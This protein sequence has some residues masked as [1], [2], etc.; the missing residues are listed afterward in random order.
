MS[1]SLFV[2]CSSALVHFS[3]F[4]GDCF[5]LHLLWVYTVQIPAV[6]AAF[7]CHQFNCQ[8][9]SRVSLIASISFL[10]HFYRHMS[11]CFVLQTDK[12]NHLVV[13]FCGFQDP[14]STHR[15][16]VSDTLYQ[17]QLFFIRAQPTRSSSTPGQYRL[18]GIPSFIWCSFHVSR[19]RQNRGLSKKHL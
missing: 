11:Q 13:T 4:C 19:R 2:L 18:Q 14:W 5:C 9:L 12:A 7:L 6:N 17:W 1:T 10:I 15:V 8:Y 3:L 16:E